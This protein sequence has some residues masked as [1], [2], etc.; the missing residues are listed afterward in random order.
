MMEKRAFTRF[1]TVGCDASLRINGGRIPCKV[2]EFSLKSCVVQFAA[3]QAPAVTPNADA[4]VE[5]ADVGAN[6]GARFRRKPA[7]YSLELKGSVDPQSASRRN[8][9]GA[10]DI[11]H[12][13]FHFNKPMDPSWQTA[14]IAKRANGGHEERQFTLAQKDYED[15]ERSISDHR[16]AQILLYTS[17]ISVTAVIAAAYFTLKA[18]VPATGSAFAAWLAALPSALAIASGAM[19]LQKA[20]AM[21]KLKAYQGLLGNWIKAGRFPPFYV[22]WQNTKDA[23]TI[24]KGADCPLKCSPEPEVLDDLKRRP[25]LIARQDWFLV[26]VVAAELAI[27]LLSGLSFAVEMASLA[28][29]KSISMYF[30]FA[31]GPVVVGLVAVLGWWVYRIAKGIHSVEAYQCLWYNITRFCNRLPYGYHL[32]NRHWHAPA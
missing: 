17:T 13:V 26:V 18:T 12:A 14:T 27:V 1:D 21:N 16:R 9:Q 15:L 29:N 5:I 32:R 6:S 19:I 22:G 4:T 23:L 31:L 7:T 30:G 10:G 11:Q 2:T 20:C 3:D 25:G 28:S 8:D 24:C